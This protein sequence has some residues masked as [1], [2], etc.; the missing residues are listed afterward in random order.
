MTNL[1]SNA[2]KFTPHGGWIRIE[3]ARDGAALELAVRDSGKGIPADFLPFVFE[4]FKQADGSV[5]RAHG[6]LGLGLAIARHVIELHGGTIEAHSD[7]EG[8]GA[9]F[10]VRLPIAPD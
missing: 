9:S 10:I 5:T 3:L 4:R 1:V 6:G 7:G 2:V 8:R